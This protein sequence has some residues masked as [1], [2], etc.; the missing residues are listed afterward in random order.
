MSEPEQDGRRFYGKYRGVVASN[1]DPTFRGRL[2][3]QVPDVLADDPC[4]WAMP[5][6]PVA[7]PQMGVFALPPVNAGVWVEF[8]R[9]DPTQAI[10]VGCFPGSPADLPPLAQT[11]PPPVDNFVLQTLGQ[12]ALIVNDVPGPA[13]GLILKSRTG[14]AIIVNDTGI[15]LSNNKGATITLVGPTVDI[16]VGGLNVT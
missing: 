16:N 9:G 4:I 3:V 13:G 7:G 15:Y 2:L 6:L 12:N 11:P 5:A 14:V 1:I 8:E 10:W